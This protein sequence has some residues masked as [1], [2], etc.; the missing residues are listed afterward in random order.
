MALLLLLL[1]YLQ[2]V[3]DVAVILRYYFELVSF[4]NS[5]LVVLFAFISVVTT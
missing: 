4:E 5:V 2:K 1:N 3:V